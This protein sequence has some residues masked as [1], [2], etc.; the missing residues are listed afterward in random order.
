[1][2]ETL[3]APDM[4][5]FVQ[6]LIGQT[7]ETPTGRPNRVLV[8]DRDQVLVGTEKSPE[9]RW[10]PVGWLQDAADR[11]WSAG[12]LE[13]SVASLGHRRTAFVAAVL[14]LL[15]GTIPSRPPRWIRLAEGATRSSDHE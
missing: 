7:I 9:G 2:V 10:V 12:E 1:M 4:A 6:T 8:A 15:P 14:Q 13:I 3:S 5:A 11:L